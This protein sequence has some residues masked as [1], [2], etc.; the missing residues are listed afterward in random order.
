VKIPN[1]KEEEKMIYEQNYKRLQKLIPDLENLP[2][3]CYRKSKGGAVNE[4]D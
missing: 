3:N 4:D 1:K 2:A